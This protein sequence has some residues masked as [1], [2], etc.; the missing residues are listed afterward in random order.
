MH[1]TAPTRDDGRSPLSP[2][3]HPRVDRWDRSIDRSR[4]S[5]RGRRVERARALS[6]PF[7]ETRSVC[8]ITQCTCH[9]YSLDGHTKNHVDDVAMGAR[10][11][12]SNR[13]DRSTQSIHSFMH[14]CI[15][16]FIGARYPRR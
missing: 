1:S 5:G 8:E 15:R 2:L 13:S 9:T 12:G 6:R 3:S 14:A 10:S 4:S 7:V 16:S 11:I